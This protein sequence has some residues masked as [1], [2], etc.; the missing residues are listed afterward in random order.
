[1][2]AK[3]AFEKDFFKLLNNKIFGKTME[4]MRKRVDTR[5]VTDQKKLSKFVSKP[6]YVNSKIFNKNLVA[7][8]KIKDTLVLGKPA[9]VGMCILD[10]SKRLMYDFHYNCI[11][12]RY[13]SKAK[14]VFTD[15][16]SLCYDRDRGYLWGTVGG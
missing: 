5:L 13:N 10:V 3:N 11:K 6:T 2:N 7:V 4:N 16:D 1:M 8:H 12:K 14:L 9:Y 15:K